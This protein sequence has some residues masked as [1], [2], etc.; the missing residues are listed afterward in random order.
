MSTTKKEIMDMYSFLREN[1][2]SI[3]S[4]ALEFMKNACLEKLESFEFS[5]IAVKTNIK[6]NVL[7]HTVGS[8]GSN[9]TFVFCLSP[10]VSFEFEAGQIYRIS[11]LKLNK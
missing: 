7:N 8:W 4:E 9:E 10:D 3:P 5:N 11:I 2:N 6:K 1:N